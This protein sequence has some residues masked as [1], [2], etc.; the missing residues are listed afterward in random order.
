MVY[1]ISHTLDNETIRELYSEGIMQEEDL[2]A[3]S[4]E[5]VEILQRYGVDVCIIVEETELF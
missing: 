2:E 1:G 4:K 3:Y 5:D